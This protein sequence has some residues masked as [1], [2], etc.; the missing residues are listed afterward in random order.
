MYIEADDPMVDELLPKPKW[1][2]DTQF[3]A[4]QPRKRARKL[5][6]GSTEMILKPLESKK[7]SRPTIPDD[8]RKFRHRQ[9][10]RSDLPRE[11]KRAQLRLLHKKRA[12]FC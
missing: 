4:V 12:N 1:K 3:G 11:D 6:V 10:Y 7:K 9:M 2:I 8:V 5:D